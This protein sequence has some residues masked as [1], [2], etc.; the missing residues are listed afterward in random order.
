[1]RPMV[2][3]ST[4][5]KRL[6][7]A[8]AAVLFLACQGAAVAYARAVDSQQTGAAQ[9]SCHESS[10]QDSKSTSKSDCQANCQSQ[11]NSSSQSFA[12]IYAVTDLPAI[13]VRIDR[14]VAVADSALSA[15][16]P[17]L[18]IESPP[19]LILHCCLRN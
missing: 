4:S 14:T 19:L 10:Q 5:A 7:A 15:E 13:T 6:V 3:L 12:N 9:S 11:H 1:M 18:R 2:R 17:L 16:P 8:G